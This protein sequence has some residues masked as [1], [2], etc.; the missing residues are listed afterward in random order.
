MAKDIIITPLDGDI[1]FNNTAGTGSGAITQDGNNL[2]I[3]NALG[4]VLLGDGASDVYIGDGTNNVD[5]LFE[6]SGAIKAEDGSTGVTLTIGSGD[7]TLALGSPISSATTVLGDLTVGVDDTGHDVTFFGATSGKKMLWDQSADTLVVDGTLDINGDASILSGGGSGT[8]TVGR[9]ANENMVIFVDDSNTTITGVQDDD[10]NAPHSFIL[11]RTFLGSG[12]NNLVAGTIT[13]QEFHTEFVSASIIFSSGSTKFGDS[14]DDIHQFS[15]SLRVTGS[16]DHYFANGNVG[17]GTTAPSEK[18]HVAGNITLGNNKSIAFRDSSGNAGTSI[19]YTSN[20]LFKMS[21]A[22]AGE[23]RFN[24]GFGDNSNNKITFYTRGTLE[25]MIITNDGNVGIGTTSPTE[26][27][28]VTGN[29]SASGGI[30]SNSTITADTYFA[31][32]DAAVVLAPA[33]GGGTVY[34]RPNGVGSGTGATSVSSTGKLTVGGAI[35][36]SGVITGA[37]LDINGDADISGNITTATWAGAIIPE[38]KLEN[39]SGTNT[40]DNAANTTYG[41]V[42]N[43]SKAT[44]FTS[45]TFTGNVTASGNISASGTIIADNIVVG[46][47]TVDGSGLTANG[48]FVAQS[49]DGSDWFTV[50][51]SGA[52][53]VVFN[54]Q[55][56]TT[57]AGGTDLGARF[58]IQ[59][60]SDSTDHFAIRGRAPNSASLMKVSSNSVTTGDI[61]HITGLGNVGIGTAAPTGKLHVS[62]AVANSD[63][64]VSSSGNVGIGTTDPQYAKLQVNGTTLFQGASQIQGDLSL[65]GNIKDLNHDGTAFVYTT[66][67]YTG[68]SELGLDL[69]FVR[70]IN[71]TNGGNIGIGTTTPTE[72]LQVTGNISASGNL[73]IG[74]GGD[75]VSRLMV[76]DSDSQVTLEKSAGGY[77]TSLGFDSNQNYLTYYSSPGMLIGYGSTT[78]AAPSVNTLFLKADGNVGIGTTSPSAKLHVVGDAIITGTITAQEFHTEFVSASIIFTSGSTKFGDSSDDIHQFSGSLRVTGSGDHLFYRWKCWYRNQFTRY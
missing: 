57:Q 8:L 74:N 17:I 24:A 36:A 65:R 9:N 29:I 49:S 54:S 73:S 76:V 39:Q 63:F 28:T 35:S 25:R 67:R 16:G 4:D 12:A 51:K 15:G 31:S 37:S 71:A 5:I 60:V 22:N 42:T 64:Y 23:L 52:G 75:G 10:T 32:S 1:V 62:G 70:S 48:R 27:L 18:L 58:N 43:E 53:I 56:G 3:S 68:G 61:F 7:T 66:T 33:D 44:M 34:L 69:D 78:G 30:K 41:N 50:G 77:F 6:Q 72:A 13:A 59:G 2:V 21:Q 38:A 14:S 46:G 40:G 47:T 45:P 20:G 19:A 55:G 26:K 11:N